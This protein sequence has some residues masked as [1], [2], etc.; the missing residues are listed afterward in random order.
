MN[1]EDLIEL[2]ANRGIS[3][4]IKP[5][6]WTTQLCI[7]KIGEWYMLSLWGTV[8]TVHKELAPIMELASMEMEKPW[9]AWELIHNKSRPVFKHRVHEPRPF[10]PI[11]LDELDLDI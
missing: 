4:K 6:N 8:L 5:G 11:S 3:P 2:R 1:S 7:S 10:F 9:S